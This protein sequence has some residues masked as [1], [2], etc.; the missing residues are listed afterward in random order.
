[1][2]TVVGRGNLSR[3]HRIL[4]ARADGTGRP[5]QLLRRGTVLASSAPAYEERR[6]SPPGRPIPTGGMDGQAPRPSPPCRLHPQAKNG[7]WQAGPAERLPT[8]QAHGGAARP[9]YRRRR[10]ARRPTTRAG[11]P[12][13]CP[14][15]LSWPT[16]ERPGVP[17]R[18]R[19]G[20]AAP[21]PT[22]RSARATA[23]YRAA[24]PLSWPTEQQPRAQQRG[25]G[26]SPTLRAAPAWAR[27]FAASE[28][29]DGAEK[30]IR[31]APLLLS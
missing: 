7:R 17:H 26:G 1:M 24:G 4:G 27:G 14:R 9:S 11:P 3:R 8:S 13:E 22:P 25:H 30:L 15:P 31:A 16:E 20:A 10:S 12:T 6:V 19:T 18:R 21:R 28:S 5:R 2:E 23:T 29:K